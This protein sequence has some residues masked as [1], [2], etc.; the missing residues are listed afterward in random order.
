MVWLVLFTLVV[1]GMWCGGCASVNGRRAFFL[2][3][4]MVLTVVHTCTDLAK[5]YPT[6]SREGIDVV[7]ATPFD[8]GLEPASF[9]GDQINVTIQSV[10]TE[11]KV[12]GTYTQAFRMNQRTTRTEMWVIGNSTSGGGTHHSRCGR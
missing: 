1:L 6:G 3:R 8:I 10:D 4:G 12:T 2:Q 5:V 9:G 7:G 11:G